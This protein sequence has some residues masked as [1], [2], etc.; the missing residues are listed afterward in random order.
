MPRKQDTPTSSA[1]AIICIVRKR[2]G[3]RHS[4][5]SL[6]NKLLSWLAG[7]CA[8]GA[9]VST[10]AFAWANSSSVSAPVL[11]SSWSLRSSSAMFI[12]HLRSGF[13]RRLIAEL[14]LWHGRG[15]IPQRGVGPYHNGETP[16]TSPLVL[17]WRG[18]LAASAL[19]PSAAPE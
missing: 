9:P 13:L 12:I 15:T 1:P 7:L 3:V 18:G 4:V 11:C 19:I 14:A 5:G 8:G 10:A 6:G 16:G 2:A 17:A